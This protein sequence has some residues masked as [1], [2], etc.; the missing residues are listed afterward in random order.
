MTFIVLC[1]EL[2]FDILHI[3]EHYISTDIVSEIVSTYLKLK[4]QEQKF[5]E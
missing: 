4:L 1:K 3:T 2:L 5:V